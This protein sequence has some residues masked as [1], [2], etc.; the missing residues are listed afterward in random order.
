M[1]APPDPAWQ[2]V[3]A[4][5]PSLRVLTI[6]DAILDSYWSGEARRIS[7][8]A[9]VPIVEIA[10]EERRLGG[11]ANAAANAASLG[12]LSRLV[13]VVG[14]DEAGAE[15]RKLLRNSGID[16]DGVV[17]DPS[18][19]TS[20]KTRVVARNQQ[21]VRL[22]WESRL[23]VSAKAREETLEKARRFIPL[24]DAAVVEDYDK[25]ALDADMIAEIR[26]LSRLAGIPMVVDPKTENFWSYRGA[27]CV[28]PNAQ[29]AGAAVGRRLETDEQLR[30]AAKEIIDRLELEFLLITR[31]ADGMTLYEQGDALHIPAAAREVYDV[32][33]AG[34]TVA[35]AFALGL[36]AGVRPYAAAQLA[37]CAAGL[38][39]GRLGCA[40]VSADELR[41]ALLNQTETESA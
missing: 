3:L 38:A 27:T 26:N 5:L 14:A 8:E 13:C 24:S 2:Q 7:P 35:A 36:A 6:G 30:A 15:L 11:A 4:R 21:V 20:H 17:E 18:R 19:P 1:T 41:A 31:G 40:A 9:P 32:T 39:V 33:G 12:A 23:P 22:D 10:S 28:V 34:D 16:D 25:G 37:N 29:E